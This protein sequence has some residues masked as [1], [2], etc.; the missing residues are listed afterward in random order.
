[1]IHTRPFPYKPTDHEC[2]R[3]SN[4]YLMS[5]MAIIVAYL[6]P[7]LIS[8]QPYFFHG[9]QKGNLFCQVALFTGHVVTIGF[10]FL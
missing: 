9:E 5:L 4:S 1:M 10:V 2:E 3:A 8:W 6:F 7:L